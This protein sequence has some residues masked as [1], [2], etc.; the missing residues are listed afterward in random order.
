MTPTRALGPLGLLADAYHSA[1]LWASSL[2]ASPATS[3][4]TPHKKSASSS[5]WASLALRAAG[6]HPFAPSGGAC[7]ALVASWFVSYAMFLITPIGGS[8]PSEVRRPLGGEPPKG[9]EG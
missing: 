9:G 5:S 2:L 6:P 7:G 3:S 8:R 4:R 1:A